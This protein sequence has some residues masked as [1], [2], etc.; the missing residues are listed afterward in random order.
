MRTNRESRIYACFCRFQAVVAGVKI[1]DDFE[2]LE[3]FKKGL[4]C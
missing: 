2:F 3:L 1:D 4:I